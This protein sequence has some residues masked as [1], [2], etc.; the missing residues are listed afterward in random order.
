MANKVSPQHIAGLSDK[1]YRGGDKGYDPLTI[2]I[3]HRCG[4]TEINSS[5]VIARHQDIIHVHTFVRGKWEDR[6]QNRG[7]QVDKILEK[8]IPTFPRLSSIDV[9]STV[10]FYDIFQ[11]T[12]MIYLL[13][14]TPF[15][16][17]SIKM[18]YEA[19][20][21]LGMGIPRYAAIVRVLFKIL[22]PLLPKLIHAFLHWST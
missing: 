8:G 5:A 12:S 6:Y 13:P 14:I 20:C 19:L 1:R 3:V 16:C 4:Y 17:I 2:P 11:K 15:D 7:P 22:P 10:E 18:G 21:P 9:K